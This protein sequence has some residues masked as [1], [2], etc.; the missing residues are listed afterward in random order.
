MTYA[1]LGMAWNHNEQL[2]GFSM[3]HDGT[4]R[5]LRRDE[6]SGLSCV[7]IQTYNTV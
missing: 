2:V 6:H 1:F 7:S 5:E 3:E 4:R